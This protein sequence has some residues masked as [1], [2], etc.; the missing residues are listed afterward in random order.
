MVEFEWWGASE[1]DLE[2]L[3]EAGTPHSVI[4]H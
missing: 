2:D 1:E 3:K 4:L